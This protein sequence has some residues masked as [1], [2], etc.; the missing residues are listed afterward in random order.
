MHVAI[1]GAGPVGLE[2]A[3]AALDAG[4]PFTVFESA[5]HPGG[6]VAMWAHVR[7]FTPW[8]MIV[9][10]RMARHLKAAGVHPPAGE[11]CPT[12]AELVRDLLEPLAHVSGLEGSIAYDTRV[13]GVSR[14]GLLKHEEIGTGR[15]VERPFRLLVRGPKGVTTASAGLVLDCT[16]TYAS[17]NAAGDGGIPAPG[18]EELGDRILRRLPDLAR[19]WADWRDRTILLLGS[20][21]S[22]QAAVRDF[23]TLLPSAPAT[24]VIWSVRNPNPDWGE[25]SEDPL[26]ERQA[27]ADAA[28]RAARG[29]VPGFRVEAGSTV[30]RFSADG[31]RVRVRLHGVNDL[32]VVVDK[33]L[34]LTGFVPDATLYR[35]L[36]V[37]ECYATTAPMELA[38]QLLG[39]ASGD[40][41]Q[42]P[43]YGIAALRSPEP[44]FFIL[45][46][47]SYGRN[48]QFLMRSGYD[49]VDEVAAAYQL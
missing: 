1:L 7:L 2:A 30:D 48:S 20:G 6:H 45:G 16:G 26:A 13:L 19:D 38:A 37:H 43:S 27:L 46:A 34:S 14:E 42:P 40:C 41:L 47:K 35:Q 10:D 23:S 4:W 11:Y 17:P 18:E 29:E 9:S 22:A 28:K 31:Q 25:I 44:N 33:V 36:Q 32:E 8:S 5:S 24:R 21:K 49:Q 3:L 39:A 15:R 12:G